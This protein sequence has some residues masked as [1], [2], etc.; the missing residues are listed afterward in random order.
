M[1]ATD[2]TTRLFDQHPTAIAE[3]VLVLRRKG[4]R[5]RAVLSA[6][7]RIPRRLFLPSERHQVAYR[8]RPQP[9]E[10]GQSIP[11]PSTVA[12]MTEALEVS[13]GHRVL[14]IGTGSGYQ[15]AVLAELGAKVYTVDRYATLVYLARQRFAALRFE[16]I[17]SD[18]IDGLSGWEER[19]PFDR[20]LFSGAID[21][22][23]SAV[24]E[25]LAPGGVIVAPVGSGRAVQKI[26]R[27]DALQNDLQ[28]K[29]IAAAR[30]VSLSSD[31]AQVL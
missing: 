1:T 12:I 14:H 27:F 22:V 3:L 11:A 4:V 24:L 20:I 2:C 28:S 16:S 6:I 9:I 29:A 21:Q 13:E 15:A 18:V 5:D 26:T 10:C 17:T 25:Q 8:D 19:R 23:P 7:E 30:F 31:I